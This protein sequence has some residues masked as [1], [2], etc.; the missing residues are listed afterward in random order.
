MGKPARRLEVITRRP[1][2]PAHPTPL[3]FVHGAFIGAWCWDEH[4]LPFFAERGFTAHAL[5]LS[6][7]GGSDGRAEL[8]S[9]KIA[10]YVR[11]VLQVVNTLDR[12]PVLIG[13]S[14]GGFVVQKV[15]EHADCPA[16]ALLC[17]VPPRGLAPAAMGLLM[18]QPGLLW[19]LNRVL[20]GHAPDAAS[21]R[22]GLFHQPVDEARLDAFLARCQPESLRAIWDMT[23]FDLPHPQLEHRPPM[24]VLGT[25]QDRLI[26]PSEAHSTAAAW[27][28][29]AEI[30]EGFGH[31]LMLEANWP[32]VAERLADWL[33]QTLPPASGNTA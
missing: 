2:G 33:L 24:L 12:P 11:D 26:P 17:A 22:D 19:T 3:L 23:A 32:L 27:G 6:G 31:A 20:A 15:L 21:V 4:F 14:M 7:H 25:A 8:D 16:A 29:E 13:H 30:F 9:L 5:S 10:D 18:Q 28:V 1:A